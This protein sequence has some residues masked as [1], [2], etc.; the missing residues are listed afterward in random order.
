MQK[1]VRTAASRR[2]AG[3]VGV[4]LALSLAAAVV[5]ASASAEWT[6]YRYGSLCAGCRDADVTR[7][8][9]TASFAQADYGRY[10][11]AGAHQPGSWNLYGGYVQGLNEACHNYSGQNIGAM[12]RNPHT[13]SQADVWAHAGWVKNGVGSYC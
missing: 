6:W 4:L 1:T 10:I 9:L 8:A 5:P 2:G 11:Q 3:L 12:V 13:V 7:T